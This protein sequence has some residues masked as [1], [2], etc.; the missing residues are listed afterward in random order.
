MA[1]SHKLADL[2]V[3]S[4][5]AGSIETPADSAILQA[6]KS[7]ILSCSLSEESKSRKMA[8]ELERF[9]RDQNNVDLEVLDLRDL[10]LPPCDG[11][12]AYDHPATRKLEAALST[13][14]AVVFAVPIYNYDVNAAAKNVIELAGRH[15]TDK[16]AGFLCSAGGHRSYMAVMAVANSLMLDF[17]TV[18]VPRFVYA[19]GDE[20]REGEDLSEPIRERLAKFG[21]EFQKLAR[22]VHQA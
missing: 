6:M 11:G 20:I 22:A 4:F 1:G 14:D 12:S 15:L 8:E 17:R 7:L 5:W 2:K 16:V 18:I 3:N 13:A 9:W 21:V 19:G 10:A